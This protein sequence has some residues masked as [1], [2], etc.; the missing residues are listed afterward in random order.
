MKLP[1]NGRSSTKMALATK[2]PKWHGM[3]WQLVAQHLMA[4]IDDMGI[5]NNGP[6]RTIPTWACLIGETIDL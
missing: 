2:Q 1:G 5:S 3:S 6:P 4:S